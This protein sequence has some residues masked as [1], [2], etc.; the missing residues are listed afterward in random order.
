[1]ATAERVAEVE[2]EVVRMQALMD[3]QKSEFPKLR[4]REKSSLHKS[5]VEDYCEV[6][7]GGMKDAL[8]AHW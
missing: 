1:M 8:Q 6:V 5:D 7:T 3:A 2:R 4:R